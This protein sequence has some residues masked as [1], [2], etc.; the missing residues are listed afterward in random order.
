M[1]MGGTAD[2]DDEDTTD[3]ADN[4]EDD[5]PAKRRAS[6]QKQIR[7]YINTCTFHTKRHMRSDGGKRMH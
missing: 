3:S 6:V 2:D 4:D 5:D 7:R 1:A